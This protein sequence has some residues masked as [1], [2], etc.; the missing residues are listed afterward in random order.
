MKWIG[1]FLIFLPTL[2]FSEIELT[3]YHIDLKGKIFKIGE[4]FSLTV[5]IKGVVDQFNPNQLSLVYPT[6]IHYQ[7]DSS[8]RKMHRKKVYPKKIDSKGIKLMNVEVSHSI[9]EKP[10][11][12]LSKSQFHFK[13]IFSFKGIK[14][15]IYE[16]PNLPIAFIDSPSFLTTPRLKIQIIESSLSYLQP[17][18][19]SFSGFLGVLFLFYWIKY[20]SSKSP[21][22]LEIRTYRKF[23]RIK[24]LKKNDFPLQVRKLF[25]RYLQKK[26]K[27]RELI[28]QNLKRGDFSHLPVDQS[29][30]QKLD[31]F[32]RQCSNSSWNDKMVLSLEEKFK[33]FLFIIQKI[34]DKKN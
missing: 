5:D 26:F 25:I 8:K 9:I 22:F 34:K 33:T 18:L 15:G 23:K 31:Q 21:N 10:L 1:L 4:M 20:S 13:L 28:S 7:D 2:S 11:T 6:D 27:K 24:K 32:W 19:L 3:Y 17:Y 12:V 29:I 14:E 30:Q 16:I